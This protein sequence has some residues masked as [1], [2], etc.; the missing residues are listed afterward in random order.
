MKLPYHCHAEY[1]CRSLT[2]D[3]V[4]A[5]VDALPDSS[6]KIECAVDLDPYPLSAPVLLVKLLD[7]V[8]KHPLSFGHKV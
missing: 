6:G 5:V 3:I 4:L 7:Q 2:F 8:V 1:N